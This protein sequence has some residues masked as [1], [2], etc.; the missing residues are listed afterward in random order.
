MSGLSFGH[1]AHADSLE[2]F[3]YTFRALYCE[4]VLRSAFQKRSNFQSDGSGD[5]LAVSVKPV[6]GVHNGSLAQGFRPSARAQLDTDLGE[7]RGGKIM[8]CKRITHDNRFQEPVRAQISRENNKRVDPLY[9]S[10]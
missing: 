3:A 6:R 7:R 2:V 4:I 1:I 8:M 5:A 9:S 10:P